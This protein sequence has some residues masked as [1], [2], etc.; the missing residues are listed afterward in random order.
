MSSNVRTVR[1]GA[2]RHARTHISIVQ[3]VM[4]FCLFIVYIECKVKRISG[5]SREKN[6]AKGLENYEYS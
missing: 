3:M 2:V 6:N 4:I 1:Y 5:F